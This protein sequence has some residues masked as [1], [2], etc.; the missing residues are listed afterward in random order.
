MYEESAAVPLIV[1]HPGQAAAVC[2][3]PVSLLDLSASIPA[4][5]GVDFPNDG[6]GEPLDDIAARPTDP[7]RAV[8]SE[9]HAVGAVSGA[10]MVRKG[11]WK[12][13]HYVGFEPELFDL[14]AD[15]EELV[16]L[17]AEAVDVRLIDRQGKA[18]GGYDMLNQEAMQ[19]GAVHLSV[20]GVR[21]IELDE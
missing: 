16:N 9:Y 13:I 6:P 1:A 7:E 2:E 5:F 15:P 18:V 14:A 19:G 3:T 21:L 17:A 12:L 10:Y 8:F 4:H 11:R 20:K